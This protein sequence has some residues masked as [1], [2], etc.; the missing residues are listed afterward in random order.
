M[1][2][3]NSIGHPNT[4]TIGADPCWSIGNPPGIFLKTF[5][6]D[7]KA[8]GTAE[9]VGKFLFATVT[10]K[11]VRL[12]STICFFSFFLCITHIRYVLKN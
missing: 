9:A 6:T 2:L 11:F 8:T 10:D 5:F 12:S 1:P 7:H 3:E 4:F